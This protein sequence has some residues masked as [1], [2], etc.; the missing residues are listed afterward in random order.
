MVLI[1]LTTNRSI[2][3]KQNSRHIA[4]RQ[5]RHAQN[6]YIISVEM[7][8]WYMIQLQKLLP[9][10]IYK[11]YENNLKPLLE[12]LPSYPFNTYGTKELCQ[13]TSG[14][15][16]KNL[17]MEIKSDS[18]HIWGTQLPN[19]RDKN[20]RAT[21]QHSHSLLS[22]SGSRCCGILKNLLQIWTPKAQMWLKIR[23]DVV[24]GPICFICNLNARWKI[25]EIALCH[26]VCI[27]KLLCT[28]NNPSG[29]A[30]QA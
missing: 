29:S 3:E 12:P 16:F 22:F 17:C 7:N 10:K 13:N 15:K 26:F 5:A 20:G 11:W 18:P 30:V 23:P 24:L 19:A 9:T 28:Q 2:K 27:I 1:F 4:G 21:N 8:K 6:T 25:I 14:S